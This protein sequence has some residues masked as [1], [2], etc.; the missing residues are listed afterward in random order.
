MHVIT[1]DDWCVY[2]P[3]MKRNRRRKKKRW[4]KLYR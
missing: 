4:H 1:T 2:T 3:Q